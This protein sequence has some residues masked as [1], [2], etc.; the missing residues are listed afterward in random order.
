[1]LLSL[2][3]RHAK[4]YLIKFLIAV[5]ALVFIFY[6]G[7]SFRSDKG[8]K[9][10][11]VNGEPISGVEYRKAYGEMLSALQRQYGNMWSDS[12]VEVFDLKKRALQGLID[13]KLLSQEAR[14]I[15]LRVT[16]DEIRS[17]IMAYP[18]F[19]F[20]GRFDERRYRTVLDQNRMSPEDFEATVSQVLLK[21]KVS[22][23]MTA[24]LP[25]TEQEALEY[26]TYTNEQTRIRFVT[27]TPETFRESVQL[28]PGDL[29][30]Y[31]SAH[32]EGYR[33]PEQ[34][35]VAYIEVNPEQFQDRV[36]VSDEEMRAYYEDNLD[37]YKVKKQVKARHILFRLPEDA[38]EEKEKEVRERAREIHEQAKAEGDFAELA[39]THSEGPTADE[40]GELGYFS[41]GEMVKPFEEAAFNMEPGEISDLVRTQFGFHIIKVEDVR[42]ARTKPLEEVRDEIRENLLGLAAADLAHE[43]ALS[44]I[45]QMPYDVDLA[46]Y[47][48]EQGVAVEKTPF[49]SRN[50][51]IPELG[52]DDRL[53]EVIFSLEPNAVSDVIEHDGRFYL[54][55]VME[56]KEP[57]LPELGE[58]AEQVRGDLVLERARE[59]ARSEAENLLERLR[60]GEAWETLVA[61][62]GLEPQTSDLFKRGGRIQES[63]PPRLSRK[64]PLAS[65]RRT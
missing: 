57:Y 13:E 58:V 5:I 32:R 46:A 28:E 15:G 10:A 29:E 24:F 42:E 1:M 18:A 63:E 2:M 49:F 38:S 62:E 41:S 25:I 37:R 31:F 44:L 30:D 60:G 51:E 61:D 14:R 55:Q 3:R 45:D 12:L 11:V 43:K 16:E 65:T 26:Y 6:F 47:A 50:D 54:F 8:T 22:Q 64:R 48:G 19:Q 35:R 36:Q 9:V 7:Y 20:Q 53:R 33:I 52:G 56:K 4:S 59:K 27:L 17:E 23:F 34:V 39:R 21:D 40:G